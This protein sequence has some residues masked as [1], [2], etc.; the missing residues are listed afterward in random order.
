MDKTELICV[1]AIAGE[2]DGKV[3]GNHDFDITR[4]AYQ[5]EFRNSQGIYSTCKVCEKQ[6]CTHC[7][8]PYTEDETVSDLLGK[9]GLRRNDT[10]FEQSSFQ[11]GKELIC[12][13]SWHKSIIGN[14]FDFL[15][16][17]TPG[18]KLESAVDAERND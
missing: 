10:L 12:Q 15:A 9:M 1:G 18:E 7:P 4:M 2:C 5:L 11:R 6:Q 14:L 17:A 16:T 3:Q 8:V 13:V